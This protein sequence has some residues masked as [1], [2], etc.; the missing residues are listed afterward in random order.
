MKFGTRRIVNPYTGGNVADLTGIKFGRLTPI[1]LS[2]EGKIKCPKW[3][4]Q[5]D[6][7]KT[8]IVRADN[9]RSGKSTSCGCLHSELTA[10]HMKGN[11]YG[12]LPMK[13]A[14]YSEP[15]ADRYTRSADRLY[16]VYKSMKMRCYNEKSPNYRNYG[17]RGVRM[18]DEWLSDFMAFR[19][20][21]LKNGYSYSAKHGECTIDRIDVNGNYEPS[22][23]RWANAREQA[24]NKRKK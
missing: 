22:N 7:G 4:C 6:C 21:A 24:A 13:S 8:T 11:K 1:R 14:L 23:C 5:C 18:C 9:L 3:E 20:W 12:K 2:P 19:T 15:P 10:E 16:K 17:G